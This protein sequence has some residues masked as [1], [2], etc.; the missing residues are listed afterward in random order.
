MESAG[1]YADRDFAAL[2]EIAARNA[3]LE[4]E[5]ESVDV[6]DGLEPRQLAANPAA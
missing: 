5:P 1:P 2:L 3:G 6:S 4:L